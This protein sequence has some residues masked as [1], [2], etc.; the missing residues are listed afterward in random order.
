[1]AGVFLTAIISDTLFNQKSQVHQ[2]AWFPGGENIQRDIAT[3]R[4][5]RPGG[6]FSEIAKEAI[7]GKSWQLF[8]PF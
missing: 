1:M 6:P 8:V 7:N 2:E 4:L 5:N 3:N